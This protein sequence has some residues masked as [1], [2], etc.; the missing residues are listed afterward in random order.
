MDI[1]VLIISWLQDN[2]AGHVLLTNGHVIL[3]CQHAFLYRYFFFF[4]PKSPEGL[5]RKIKR[6]VGYFV[7]ALSILQLGVDQLERSFLMKAASR[8]NEK[9]IP[10]KNC[11]PYILKRIKGEKTTL[12]LIRKLRL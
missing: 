2:N 5:C 3:T 1:T 6:V 12:V 10:D 11:P 8:Y 9:I 4:H 7:V